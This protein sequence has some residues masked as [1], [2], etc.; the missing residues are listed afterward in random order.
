MNL[1]QMT[2]LSVAGAA[3]GFVAVTSGAA[4]RLV[5]AISNQASDLPQISAPSLKASTPKAD[6]KGADVPRSGLRRVVLDAGRNGHFKTEAYV[7]GRSIDVLADTGA[8]WVVLTW[9]DARSIGLRPDQLE[10]VCCVNTANG[11]AEVAPVTLDKV[12]IGHITV[13]D[14]QAAVGARGALSTNLLGMTFID[15]LAKFELSSGR[16]ILEQ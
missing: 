10:F 5:A 1:I 12:E 14:V 9:E 16:L 3:L 13:R 2:V 7:N 8:S 6:A 4:E 15:R 11:Q